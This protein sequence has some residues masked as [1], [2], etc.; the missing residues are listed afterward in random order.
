MTKKIQTTKPKITHIM[1]DGSV[2]KDI[3]KKTIPINSGAYE[4]IAAI[5]T[6]QI[7]TQKQIKS[8]V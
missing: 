5:I 8:E 4:I 7:A 2:C 3:S 6:K 1:A